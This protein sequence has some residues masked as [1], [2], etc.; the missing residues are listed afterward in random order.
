MQHICWL[1]TMAEKRV[2]QMEVSLEVA[3]MV[4]YIMLS[5]VSLVS[6]LQTPSRTLGVRLGV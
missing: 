2:S 6:N 3:C 5:R 1:Q 4:D